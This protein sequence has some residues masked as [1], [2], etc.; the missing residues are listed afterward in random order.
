MEDIKFDSMGGVRDHDARDAP[1]VDDDS[2]RGR[3]C[4][5]RIARSGQSGNVRSV[6]T[7]RSAAAIPLPVRSPRGD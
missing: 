1:F 4:G 5:N 3:V 2:S 7:Y 6:R